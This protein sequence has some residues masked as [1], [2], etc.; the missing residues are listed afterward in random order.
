MMYLSA[1]PNACEGTQYAE[2][3]PS[4]CGT[5]PEAKYS[6]E[7]TAANEISVRSC[8]QC[9]HWL[10]PVCSRMRRPIKIA[11]TTVSGDVKSITWV[12]GRSGGPPSGPVSE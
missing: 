9:T 10:S 5:S 3:L 2:A 4:G 11:W 1:V 6:A 12:R 8:E 7:R